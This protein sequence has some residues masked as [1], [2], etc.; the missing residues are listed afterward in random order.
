M[1]GLMYVGIGIWTAILGGSFYFARRFV[2]AIE[3]RRDNEE[4]LS[5]IGQRLA[6]L[7]DSTEGLRADVS[8]L[9]A[10]QEFTTRLL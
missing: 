1:P 5:G 3:R 6:A 4:A 10:G 7:E 8:R 2:R 9:D